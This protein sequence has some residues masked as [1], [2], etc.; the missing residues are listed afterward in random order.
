MPYDQNGNYYDPS[1]QNAQLWTGVGTG[2]V[3]GALAGSSI[4]PGW[5][6]LVG[7]LAGAGWGLYSG[8]HQENQAKKLQNQNPYPT[9]TVPQ[10]IQQNAQQAN[11]MSLLG[12]PSAQYQEAMKNIQRQQETAIIAAQDRK[13]GMDAIAGT[14]QQANDALQ[15]LS[16]A[17]VGARR[18][19]IQTAYGQNQV[20]GQ[21][22]QSAFDWNSK[23][24][25]LQNYQYAMSL[26]GAGNQN[27]TRGID[28]G[29][30]AIARTNWG[31]LL[32]GGGKTPAGTPNIAINPNAALSIPNLSLG[33]NLPVPTDQ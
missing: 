30:S 25:Y 9:Q 20:L 14:N 31:S 15:Q 10:G 2:A 23:Q 5:G 13:A 24:K 29:A 8:L 1:E 32:G 18:Q 17:D 19:N 33:V 21:Y 11:R 16:A 22:Q 27:I 4:A 7:G 12:L 28:T 26:L 6:T 3:S